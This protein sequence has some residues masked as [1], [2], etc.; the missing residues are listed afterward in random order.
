MKKLLVIFVTFG[1]I[2]IG[3]PEPDGEYS[4]I[5]HG[6]NDTYG[7]PPIDSK[8]Y[9]YDEEAV[10]LDKYTLYKAGYTFKSW[11]TSRDGTGTSHEAGGRIKITGTIFLYAMWE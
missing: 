10:V 11:N 9:K 3:C 4:V 5:Y 1:L 8:K 7:Y 2:F 6:D